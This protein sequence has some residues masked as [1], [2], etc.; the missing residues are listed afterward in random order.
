MPARRRSVLVL[1]VG[2]AALAAAMLAGTYMIAHGH[3]VGWLYLCLMQ[4][5][6]G[7]YDVATRQWGF[8]ATSIV[9]GTLYYRGWSRRKGGDT[10]V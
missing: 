10:S 7:A 4:L 2:S 9:G 6:A 1:T 5:P 8:I 3:R